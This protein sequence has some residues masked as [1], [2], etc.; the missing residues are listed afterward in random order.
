M[1]YPALVLAFS[2]IVA[3]S[4]MPTT[5]EPLTLTGDW[6]QAPAEVTRH[7]TLVCSF[8]ATDQDDADSARD[9]AESGGFGMTSELEGL[10]GSGAQIA[11]IGG[12]LNFRG[13]SNFQAAH[14]TVRFAVRG[15]VWA[16]DTPRWLFDARGQDRIGILREPGKL[17]LRVSER[18]RTDRAIGE[19]VLETGEVSVSDWH[20]VVASWD[21]E[22]G[23]GWIALD[24]AGISGEMAFSQDSRPAFAIY[25]GGG[26]GG[27]TGGLNLPGLAFDDFVLYDIPLPI[28]EAEG[29]S[30]G[31]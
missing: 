7:T 29:V 4:V 12:H 11:E 18:W 24:G 30:A 25:L 23:V 21:R 14:G 16:E 15:D 3:L 26:F 5:A 27:R 19:V 13:G 31:G 20:T 2:C 6:W 1:R 17:S 10:H 28:L 9:F 8:D 22:A